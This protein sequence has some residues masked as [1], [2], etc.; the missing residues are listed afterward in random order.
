MQAILNKEITKIVVTN[1]K[2]QYNFPIGSFKYF[3]TLSITK[4]G[5]WPK[6]KDSYRYNEDIW[7]VLVSHCCLF[8]FM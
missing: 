8:M 1:V 7:Q 5:K 6:N 4:K 2:Y 3:A